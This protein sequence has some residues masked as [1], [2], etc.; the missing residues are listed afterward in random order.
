MGWGTSQSSCGLLVAVTA[1]NMFV[2]DGS[3]LKRMAWQL[4]CNIKHSPYNQNSYCQ[5]LKP[6]GHQKI[7]LPSTATDSTGQKLHSPRHHSQV[8]RSYSRVTRQ[9]PHR[10]AEEEVAFAL[11]FQLYTFCCNQ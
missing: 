4:K 7:V 9:R 6:Q 10:Q 1:A 3:L 8:A 11:H 2:Q 5:A